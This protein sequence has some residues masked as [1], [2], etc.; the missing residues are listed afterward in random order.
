M[1]KIVKPLGYTNNFTYE[2]HEKQIRNK[3]TINENSTIEKQQFE[4]FDP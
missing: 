3:I 4:Q 2:I 1:H